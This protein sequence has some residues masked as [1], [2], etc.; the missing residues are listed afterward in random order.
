MP[1]AEGVALQE[2]A[3]RQAA[4]QLAIAHLPGPVSVFRL[5]AY[6]DVFSNYIREGSWPEDD[7][8]CRS[9][10]QGGLADG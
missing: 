4:L 2:E 10:L 3:W 6:A 5:L 8:E 7:V 9:P 1:D